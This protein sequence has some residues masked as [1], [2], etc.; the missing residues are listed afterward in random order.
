[1]L[2]VP[3]QMAKVENDAILVSWQQFFEDN[4]GVMQ[5]IIQYK[6]ENITEEQNVTV[7]GDVYN[8][9]LKGKFHFP[10]EPQ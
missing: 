6:V 8:Y 3:I 1:M 5:W 4:P 10:T 9:T 2:P 7:D